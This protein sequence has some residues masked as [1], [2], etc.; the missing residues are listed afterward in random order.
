MASL[1]YDPESRTPSPLPAGSDVQIDFSFAVPAYGYPDFYAVTPPVYEAGNRRVWQLFANRL[2]WFSKFTFYAWDNT[3][4]DPNPDTSWYS[5]SA[6]QISGGHVF[7]VTL[8]GG[9][10]VSTNAV[11]LVTDPFGGFPIGGAKLIN[12]IEFTGLYPSR[13][14]NIV[15]GTLGVGQ[16]Y[17]FQG[18]LDEPIHLQGW[19]SYYDIPY[20]LVVEY[21]VQIFPL[22]AQNR[23]YTWNA[24]LW[25][26]LNTAGIS[27][28]PSLTAL[29]MLGSI[30]FMSA[31]PTPGR[32]RKS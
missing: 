24:V 10:S 2:N 28:I 6:S 29:A 32:R 9:V 5:W 11:G 21:Y 30:F 1:P 17:D 7:T 22:D 15:F 20:R 13:G 8:N 19:P 31:P 3:V 14:G 16:T 23:P 26:L 4:K 12:S 25:N 27:P 18:L